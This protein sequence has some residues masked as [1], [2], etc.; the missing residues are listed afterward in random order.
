MLNY[1]TCVSANQTKVALLL[2][3]MEF[4]VF[5]KKYPTDTHWFSTVALKERIL[6]RYTC[7]S[8]SD[9]IKLI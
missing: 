7:C 9:L 2:R 5:N 6:T 8:Y 3:D 1:W 4:M